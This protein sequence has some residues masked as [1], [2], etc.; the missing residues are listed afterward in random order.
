MTITT[1]TTQRAA[2]DKKRRFCK[3]FFVSMLPDG[4]YDV[5]VVDAERG[6]DGE[7]RIELTITLGPRVGEVVRLRAE[8]VERKAGASAADDPYGL[9]GVPGT[10]RVR[11]GEPKFRPEVA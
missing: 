5:I 9:L 1:S 11:D 4:N 2:M 6:D 10:L 3:D 8:H 7:L